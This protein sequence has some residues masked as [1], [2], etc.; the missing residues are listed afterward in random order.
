MAIIVDRD[1]FYTHDIYTVNLHGN[2]IKVTVTANVS[3]VRKWIY[4]TLYFNRYDIHGGRFVVGLGV[5]WTPECRDPPADTIQLCIGSRCLIFQLAHA[6]N[7]PR[8]LRSFLEN[9]NHTF[10]GFWNHSDRQKLETSEYQFEMY[11]DPL[12]LRLCAEAEYED[13]DDDL[14]RASVNEIVEKC[15]GYEVEQRKEISMSD[16]SDEVLS[17]EQVIYASVDAYCAF[18]IGKNVKAWKYT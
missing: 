3:V 13:D 7:V 15:L 8:I 10:V 5:Q 1:S 4:T 16:W 9:P 2:E 12:D 18:R 14:A 11:R 17:D 6:T